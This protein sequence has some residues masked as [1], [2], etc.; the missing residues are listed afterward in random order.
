MKLFIRYIILVSLLLTGGFA[1]CGAQSWGTLNVVYG[2]IPKYVKG[3][4]AVIMTDFSKTTWDEKRTMKRFWYVEYQDDFSEEEMEA[5][6]CEYLASLRD[7][8]INGFRSGMT[9]LVF[10]EEDADYTL[11]ITITNFH[12]SK[13]LWRRNIKGTGHI[14]IIDNV[15]GETVCH[16]TIN[17]V[18]GGFDQDEASAV[19]KCMKQ[20][21]ALL[22]DK[23]K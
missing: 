4:K 3:Q 5:K 6:Y 20:I 8:L 1:L 23:R 15:T 12:D 19:A 21:G 22:S 2:K 18:E 9:P 16:M 11:A 14:D 17:E 13:H 10:S 7:A